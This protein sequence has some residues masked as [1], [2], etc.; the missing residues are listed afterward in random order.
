M[1]SKT[2]LPSR[3][4]L[5]NKSMA[6]LRFSIRDGASGGKRP[7]HPKRHIKLG[8]AKDAELKTRMAQLWPHTVE[9]TAEERANLEG[10]EMVQRMVQLGAI[11]FQAA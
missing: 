8:I 10:Q 3:S 11:E 1:P 7:L 4:I 9:V 6:R 2:S 5:V